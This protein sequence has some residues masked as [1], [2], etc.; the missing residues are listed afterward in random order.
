MPWIVLPVPG[1]GEGKQE[2]AA[3]YAALG[4]DEEEEKKKTIWL[5]GHCS[6][7]EMPWEPL[8]GAWCASLVLAC[9]DSVE[10]A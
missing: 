5:S 8:G 7:A 2:K 3:C 10:P 4:Y 1:P 9:G 6:L